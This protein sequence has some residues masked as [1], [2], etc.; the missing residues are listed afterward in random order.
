M[1]VLTDDHEREQVVRKWWSENWKSLALGIVIAVGGM[2][3]VQQYKAYTLRT[4]QDKAYQVYAIRTALATPNATYEDAEKFVSENSDIYGSLVAL[5]LASVQIQKG[6]YDKALFNTRYA[7][8]NGS[9]LIQPNA[10]LATA[11][12]L[13]ELKKYDE[14]I[15]ACQ[16][17]SANAYAAEKNEVLGDIYFA[18]GKQ[19]QAHD[20]YLEAISQCKDK[21]IAIN[22]VLQMKFD[23]LIKEGETPAFREAAKLDKEIRISSTKV[24]K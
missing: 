17:I 23:N 1:D 6:E 16:K 14:A 10:A 22:P 13:L 9:D 2:V 7:M 5:E 4:S 18:Q 21:K 24:V 19:D 3:G 20:A 11:K 15:A 8:E 12:I